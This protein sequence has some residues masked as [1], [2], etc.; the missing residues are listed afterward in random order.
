[1]ATK[2]PAV[3]YPVNLP[4]QVAAAARAAGQLGNTGK[5][6]VVLPGVD[7]A[8]EYASPVNQAN[9]AS[10]ANGGSAHFT[11]DNPYGVDPAY[12][13][14]INAFN[15]NLT[16]SR[17]AIDKQLAQ[18]MGELGQRRDAAAAVVAQLPADA[19]R[20]YQ[21]SSTGLS[22]AAA[23]GQGAISPDVAGQVGA[24]AAP[25]QAAL[26]Q[27]KAGTASMQPFLNLANMA[28]YQGGT[29]LLNQQAMAGRQQLD[30]E[31]RSFLTNLLGQQLSYDQANS[32]AA[33][34]RETDKQLTSS[35]IQHGYQTDQATVRAVQSDPAFRRLEQLVAGGSGKGAEGQT[36][37]PG[38]EQ[39][40]A[41]L[42]ATG[43]SQAW[44]DAV[45]ALHPEW[46]N[47]EAPIGSRDNPNGPG[48]FSPSNLGQ[49]AGDLGQYRGR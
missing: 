18:A 35:L 26:S 2:A 7:L 15:Q 40:L 20:A 48:T 4:P 29:A 5:K 6:P 39:I 16:A 49:F 14:Y 47:P 24:L 36:L 12:L 22:Q 23:A 31:G 13:P 10:I 30:A 1:M 8:Q 32:P 28:N 25:L 9:L 44:I 45:Q 41:M 34:Q 46:F 33:I 43:K 27:N 42:R 17:A 37:R 3:S 38:G 19:A 11:A 21:G